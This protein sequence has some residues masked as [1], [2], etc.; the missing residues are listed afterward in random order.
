MTR[1]LII[2]LSMLLTGS[3]WAAGPDPGVVGTRGVSIGE[4]LGM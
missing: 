1:K 2:A 4:C 3:A